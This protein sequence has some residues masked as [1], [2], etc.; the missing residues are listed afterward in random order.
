MTKIYHLLPD[1]KDI[2]NKKGTIISFHGGC[3][4]GGNVSYD[5]DQNML[6]SRMGYEVHQVYFPKE[7]QAFLKWVDEFDFSQ[8]ELPIYCLGR[9]SGGYLAK[10]FYE[11]HNNIVSKVLYLCPVFNPL[12][13]AQIKPKFQEKTKQFFG[14]LNPLETIRWD[15]KREFL[16][17]ARK[18][19]NVPIQVFTK[20][21]KKDSRYIE[22]QT[23]CGVL[24]STSQQFRKIIKEVF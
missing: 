15:S 1:E 23:H 16:V 3:F 18:D 2:I 4:V 24:K 9:S 17:L 13:R 22:A 12:L 14:D 19:Q 5:Q 10:I 6:L 20:E 11:N 21:Q 7:Y 8:M